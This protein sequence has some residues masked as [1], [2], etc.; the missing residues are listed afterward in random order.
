MSAE[1]VVSALDFASERF[2]AEPTTE[3]EKGYEVNHPKNL[4]HLPCKSS[5]DG[6]PD[7]PIIKS[8]D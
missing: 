6:A 3:C 7:T 5:H 1:E 2:T 8:R 4:D